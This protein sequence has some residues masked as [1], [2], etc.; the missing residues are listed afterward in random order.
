MEFEFCGVA[1]VCSVGAA[2]VMGCFFFCHISGIPLEVHVYM[3]PSRVVAVAVCVG[4]CLQ[5][6]LFLGIQY[7]AARVK[8]LN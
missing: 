7:W 8:L 6:T 1:A 4:G 2:G 5:W 3:T